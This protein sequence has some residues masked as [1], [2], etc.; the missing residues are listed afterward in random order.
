MI[1][2]ACKALNGSVRAMMTWIH[3][4]KVT[5]VNSPS[6][7]GYKDRILKTAQQNSQHKICHTGNSINSNCKT[8]NSLNSFVHHKPW[9]FLH[10]LTW[11]LRQDDPPKLR[12]TQRNIPEDSKLQILH[13][14]TQQN[15]S[16]KYSVSA[17]ARTHRFSVTRANNSQ[18]CE[19]LTLIHKTSDIARGRY[20]AKI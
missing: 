18:H 2:C 3:N 8:E 19:S 17:S 6:L 10:C 11:K 12:S 9:L 7:T 15:N 14:Q 4:A 16:L 5:T 20:N 1:I 13:H